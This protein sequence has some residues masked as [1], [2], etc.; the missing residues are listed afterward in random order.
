MNDWCLTVRLVLLLPHDDPL[1]ALFLEKDLVV[2]DF[3][4]VFSLV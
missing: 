3:L 4:L 2:V 1:D